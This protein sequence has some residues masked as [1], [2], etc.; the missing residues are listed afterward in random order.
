[1][2]IDLE[3][4]RKSVKQGLGKREK[5]SSPLKAFVNHLRYLCAC[6]KTKIGLSLDKKCT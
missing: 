2:K 6:A 1:M 5:Q 4:L 3:Y